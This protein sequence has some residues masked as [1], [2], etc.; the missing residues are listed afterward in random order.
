MLK[1]TKT[2]L[3]LI[4]DPNMYLMIEKGIRG[5]ISSIM[6]RY[7]KANHKYLKNYDS[8]KPSQYIMYLDANNLYGWAMS[9]PLPYKNFNW[10]SESELA[11]WQKTPCIL[12][13]DLEYPKNLHDYHNEYPLAPERLIIEKTE[14]LVPNLNDKKKYVVHH[15][16]LKQ[17]LKLGMKI[18]KIHRGVSFEKKDIM[19]SYISLTRT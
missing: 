3:D 19:K 10:I 1:Y 4:S 18:T 14:K 15:E 6:K 16:N 2:E 13:V 7:S 17:Y 11:H 5:E 9:K 8:Q 12:E